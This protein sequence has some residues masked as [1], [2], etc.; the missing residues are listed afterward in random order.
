MKDKTLGIV[1]GGQLGRMLVQAA[2]KMNIKTIVLDPTKDGPAGILAD[3][4]VVGKFTE[5]DAVMELGKHADAITFEI[6]SAHPGA[7]EEL[8]AQGKIVAPAGR[9]L[10]VIKDKVTQKQALQENGIP[11]AEFKP[12]ETRVDIAQVAEKF[13]YPVV[14]KTRSGGYDGRGNYVVEVPDDIGPA[15]EKLG[16]DKNPNSLYV[17]KWVPFQKELAVNITRD[18]DGMISFHPVVETVHKNNICH[19]VTAPAPV[20]EHITNRAEAIAE[21]VVKT[22]NGVGCFGIEFFLTKENNI[23]VNEIAPRV[24]N[25]G[26]HTIESCHTSQFEQHVRAVMGMPLADSS[27]KEKATVMINI[28]GERTGPA[29]PTGVEDAEK[30]PGVSVHIYGKL[31]TRPERKMGHLTAVG[32]TVEVAR[33]NAEHARSLISI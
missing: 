6:E 4:Q 21:L 30:I 17:E 32:D 5:H 33:A 7:L 26:H 9:V 2:K 13:W 23:L 3:E 12:I 27:M 1:G 18:R 19:T 8:E 29:F 10:Q 22:L 28:L 24:H 14:L 20:S 25:S 16:G 15:F 11:V 31:E